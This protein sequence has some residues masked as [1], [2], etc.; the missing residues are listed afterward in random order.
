VYVCV[1]MC[2]RVRVSLGVLVYTCAP[3][4]PAK[5][6]TYGYKCVRVRVSVSVMALM[7]AH[8]KHSCVHLVYTCAHAN[9]HM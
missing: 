7:F 2:V 4:I 5:F 1:R 8:C 9:M 6:Q 3:T